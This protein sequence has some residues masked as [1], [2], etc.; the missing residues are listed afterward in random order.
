[1]DYFENMWFKDE[2]QSSKEQKDEKNKQVEKVGTKKQFQ[3]LPKYHEKTDLYIPPISISSLRLSYQKSQHHEVIQQS[4]ENGLNLFES[5]TLYPDSQY[6]LSDLL[7]E[8]TFQ[9]SQTIFLSKAGFETGE[10]PV[11]SNLL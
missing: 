9:R 8:P 3:I 1:M 6:I 10:T 7:N 5:S 2:D 4:Y 11:V